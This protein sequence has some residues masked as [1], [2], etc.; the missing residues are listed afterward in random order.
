MFLVVRVGL[1]LILGLLL[2]AWPFDF[3]VT[4]FL[5][6]FVV[7][8]VFVVFLGALALESVV[9]VSLRLLRFPLVR[10]TRICWKPDRA[11]IF[12]LPRLWLMGA[13]SGSGRGRIGGLVGERGFLEEGSGNGGSGSGG[14]GSGGSGSGAMGA[15]LVK[16]GSSQS[17]KRCIHFPS[18]TR[19]TF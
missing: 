11:E 18:F 14:S 12:G 2:V 19:H 8:V 16:V 17:L 13:M 9:F 3:V 7:C 6:V 15:G 1:G 4:F 10:L 5:V